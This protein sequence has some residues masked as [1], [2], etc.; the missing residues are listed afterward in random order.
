MSCKYQAKIVNP[1]TGRSVLKTGKIG[2]QILTCASNK[3]LKQT[4]KWVSTGRKV[5]I[6]RGENHIVYVDSSKQNSQH[7]VQMYIVNGGVRQRTY[8]SVDKARKSKK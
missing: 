3:K 2:K 7:Y 1:A 8:V 6:G 4:S 5:S